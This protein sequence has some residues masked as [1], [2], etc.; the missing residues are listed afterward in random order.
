MPGSYATA[1]DWDRY[2][3]GPAPADI[4]RLIERA[5]ELMDSDVLL[6][7]VYDV[8]TSGMPTHADVITAFARSV[9]AQI[10]FWKDV[11]EQVDT[12]GP[13][14]GVSIGSVQL[15]Y[16]VG[17]N[18]VGPTNIGE[19]VFRPLRALPVEVFRAGTALTAMWGCA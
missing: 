2:G 19:R 18:R 9:I 8:N 12:S 7:A 16:G 6:T 17:K 11:G 14:Q 1:A 3:K 10:E 13:L 15:Q 5:T 4:D